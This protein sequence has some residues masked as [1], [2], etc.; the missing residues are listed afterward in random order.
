MHGFEVI[1]NGNVP[2][3]LFNTMI[4][5]FAS[6]EPLTP[7]HVNLHEK[8]ETYCRKNN[9]LFHKPVDAYA[10]SNPIS[11]LDQVNKSSLC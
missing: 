9:G 2:E 10:S 4:A 6:L 8:L 1:A 11:D 7:E 3:T 5:P